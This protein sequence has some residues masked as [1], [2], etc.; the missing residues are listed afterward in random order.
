MSHPRE[1]GVE[2]VA[3][4]PCV[5]VLHLQGKRDQVALIGCFYLADTQRSGLFRGYRKTKLD[6]ATIPEYLFS[7]PWGEFPE[8]RQALGIIVFLKTDQARQ[9]VDDL[10]KGVSCEQTVVVTVGRRLGRPRLGEQ[11]LQPDLP[12]D[13]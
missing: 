3:I 5:T 4:K 11:F 8:Q 13:V 6:H 9:G 12:P 1:I 2:R 7:F 10:S